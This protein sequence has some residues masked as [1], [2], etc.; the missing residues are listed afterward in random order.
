MSRGV[1]RGVV[2]D[3]E[4][5]PLAGVRVGYSI[6]SS[7]AVLVDDPPL[8]DNDGRFQCGAATLNALIDVSFDKDLYVMQTAY[9]TV[10][11]YLTK[12]APR[13]ELHIVMSRLPTSPVAG[14]VVDTF[15]RPIAG[16]ASIFGIRN[17][18]SRPTPRADS[19]S[20]MSRTRK[21]EGASA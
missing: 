6:E 21:P 5:K 19:A 7:G 17:K 20:T 18:H 9:E 1:I 13:R 14:R 12:A 2:V 15:N 16:A 8:T 4:G 10:S 3:D 11:V